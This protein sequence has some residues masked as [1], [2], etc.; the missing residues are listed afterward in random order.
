MY[1]GVAVWFLLV[2]GALA[3]IWQCITQTIALDAVGDMSGLLLAKIISIFLGP[4]GSIWGFID[5]F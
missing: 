1:V 4:I 3:N 5:M 2:V